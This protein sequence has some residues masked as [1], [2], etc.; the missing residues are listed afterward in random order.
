MNPTCARKNSVFTGP[1]LLRGATFVRH[2]GSNYSRAGIRSAKQR[3]QARSRLYF[4]RS[5]ELGSVSYGAV[6][7]T[8]V[9]RRRRRTNEDVRGRGRGK[10]R[11]KRN[12][13]RNEETRGDGA[14]FGRGE[15]YIMQSMC[16]PWDLW[17][18][19]RQRLYTPLYA[20]ERCFLRSASDGIIRNAVSKCVSWDRK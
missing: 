4:N 1:L 9:A 19:F 6:L 17:G 15:A 16:S 18:P 3:E 13:F 2:S 10:T 12:G 11:E 7:Y 5:N 14:R 20:P 8:Q